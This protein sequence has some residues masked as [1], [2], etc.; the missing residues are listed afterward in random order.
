MYSIILYNYNIVSDLKTICKP[1]RSGH[2]KEMTFIFF[3]SDEINGNLC[4]LE[5]AES[6]RRYALRSAKISRERT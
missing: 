3:I 6:I 1:L 4:L 2:G 5:E